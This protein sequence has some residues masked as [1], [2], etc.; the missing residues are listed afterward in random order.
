MPANYVQQTKGLIT[1]IAVM[2]PVQPVVANKGF[3]HT[4]TSFAV[5]SR[6]LS[7]IF[8]PKGHQTRTLNT[9]VMDKLFTLEMRVD[10]ES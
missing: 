9:L 8:H 3:S 6:R 7:C 4:S 10:T 1:A 5:V 2:I